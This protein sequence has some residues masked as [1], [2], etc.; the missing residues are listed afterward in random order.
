MNRKQGQINKN[1]AGSAKETSVDSENTTVSPIPTPEQAQKNEL[2]KKGLDAG[3]ELINLGQLDKAENLLKALLEHEP[4]FAD[5]FYNLGI[6]D[7]K[8][9]NPDKAIARFEQ[10]LD[11]NPDHYSALTA[12]GFVLMGL[13]Q[14][15]RAVELCEKALAIQETA[16]GHNYYSVILRQLGRFEDA[17]KHLERSIELNPLGVDA[18]RNLLALK[19]IQKDDPVLA[20]MHALAERIEEFDAIDKAHL[21]FAMGKSYEDLQDYDTAFSYFKQANEYKNQLAAGNSVK[22]ADYIERLPKLFTPELMKKYKDAGCDSPKP[23]FI[24]G[25]PRSG[26]TLTEQIIA[27]HPSVSAGGELPTFGELIKKHTEITDQDWPFDPSFIHHLETDSFKNIGE[28]YVAQI[29][30][31]FPEAQHITDTMPF[32]SFNIAMIRL[33]LPN[34]KIIYC[35]RDPMDIGLSIYRKFFLED[36]YWGYDLENIGTIIKAHTNLMSYWQSLP[37]MDIYECNYEQ[38]VSDPE[39]EI[40]KLI[41]FCNLDWDDA[42][43]SSDEKARNITTADTP[44]L[45]RPI[46]TAFVK[47]WKK[48]ENYAAPLSKILATD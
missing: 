25:M 26:K 9:H 46:K 39:E 5:A 24:V 35:S 19:T 7:H 27:R 21:T 20:E 40:R 29:T 28:D 41:G 3:I 18:Y 45:G 31:R 11:L 1:K 22:L 14:P 6:I 32:N 23:I 10:T 17:Q 38:L 4:R 44:M 2:L 16:T 30:G 47:E 12:L 43:L 15:E 36:L 8:R 42:C 37:D 33:A 48:Y 34:A 13:N